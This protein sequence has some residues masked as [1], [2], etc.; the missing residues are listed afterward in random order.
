MD[1]LLIRT[2]CFGD[3]YDVKALLSEGVDVTEQNK[4]LFY[5]VL[6]FR[7]H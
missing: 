2:V 1:I 5:Q 3:I 7:Y 6:L 4:V